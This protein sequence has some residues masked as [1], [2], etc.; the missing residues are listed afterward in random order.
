MMTL[1]FYFQRELSE[2]SLTHPVS[3]T[4]HQA[5]S[6]PLHRCHDLACLISDI[7][8]PVL[9]QMILLVP[10]IGLRLREV[11]RTVMDMVER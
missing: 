9:C 10:S 2:L 8:L 5:R 11:A 6:L 3:F 7:I 1:N 4:N